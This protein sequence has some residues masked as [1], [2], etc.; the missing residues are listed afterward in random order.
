MDIPWQDCCGN[1]NSKMFYWN[2]DGKKYRIGNVCLFIE[3]KDNFVSVH[4]D[5]IMA[6]KKQ[7]KAPMWKKMNKCGSWRTNIISLTTYIW[8]CTQRECKPSE[9]VAEKYTKMFESRVSSGAPEKLPGWEKPHAKTVAWSYDVEGDA[10]KCVDRFCELANKKVE[11]LHKVSSPCLDG[12]QVIQEEL[13]SVGELTQVC[14]QIVLKCLYHCTNRKTRHSVLGQQTCKSS[15]K[16][17]LRHV[18]DVFTQSDF[19]QYCCVGSTAQH[20]R[21]GQKSID[22]LVTS[23]SITGRRDFHDYAMLDAMIASALKRLLDNHIRI[24]KRVNVEEQRA[25]K[26]D[27]FLR[28]RQIA[29]MIYDISVLPELMNLFSVRLQND[30]VQDFDIRWDQALLSASDMPSN[31]ILEGLYKSKLQ[32]FVQLQTVLA[33]YHRETVRNNGQ[34]SYLR[35]KTSVKLHIDQMMRTRNFRVRNEVVERGWVTKSQNGQKACVER[36][37]GECFQWK[38]PGQCSKG[39]SCSFSHDELAQGDLCSGQRQN[40]RSSSPALNSKDW[41]RGEKCSKTGQEGSSSD[42]KGA[43]FRAVTKIVKIR[44][45]DSGILPCVT[46]TSLRP[47]TYMEKHVSSDMLRLMKSPANS[48]RKVV[49]KEQ[50]RYWRSLNNWVVYLKIL[51]WEGLLY[52]NLECWDQNTP[53]NSPRA[54]GTKFKFGKARVHREELSKSANLM[55]VVIARQNSGKDHM[56]RPCTKKDAPAEQ[57]GIWRNIF[58]SSRMRTDRFV[59]LLTQG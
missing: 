55:S 48:Q 1:H 54:P 27:R 56:R 24:R 22:D 42:K 19:R 35:L 32:D 31:V 12:H 25:Q 11:Q 45:V 7:K 47:D 15:H 20:C 28:G 34:T 58:T 41:R 51:I 4:V 57:R 39:D 29:Y 36:K 30:D 53:S 18:T 50:L 26:Y 21:L 5:D 37:M 3:N 44:H 52:V 49:R 6:G 13:E 9:I 10:R 33:L 38:A 14:S 40:R 17:G 16:N 59:L 43:K 2:L 23:Q 46:T 8:E